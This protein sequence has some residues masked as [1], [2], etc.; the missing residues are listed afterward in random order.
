ML[1]DRL[2]PSPHWARCIHR[3]KLSSPSFR[4][5]CPVRVGPIELPLS[6]AVRCTSSLRKKS[7]EKRPTEGE[8]IKSA[9]PT[10]ESDALSIPPTF[11]LAKSL[12]D[13]KRPIDVTGYW[14]SE[15][16]DG[17]RAQWSPDRRAF[18][19]RL[20][21]VFTAPDWYTS[22]LP[23]IPL[24]GELWVG[25]GLFSETVSIVKTIDSTEWHK[26][27]FVVFDVPD[28]SFGPF[29]ERQSEVKKFISSLPSDCQHIA[30][31]EQHRCS[32]Q[33]HLDK[34]LKD[35]EASGGEGVML[36][37]P[38]S[39]YVGKRSRTLLK[40]KSFYD[41]E[42]I[43]VEHISGTGKFSGLMG[44]LKCRMEC[45]NSFRIGTGFTDF[46]RANP[47]PVGSIVTYRFFELTKEGI[48]RFPSFVSVR[49]DAKGPKDA[50]IRRS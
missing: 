47:P 25:R 20:G 8:R 33:A 16:L 28:A 17:V 26:V 49:I 6:V 24:D 40:L 3:G 48:P 2:C 50:T 14:M 45:G 21:N 39:L 43:I 4:P 29:E 11:L 22:V 15:K 10:S 41:A 1:F 38:G 30:C 23:Q 13:Y 9:L 31:I 27:K 32:G 12:R 42:A 7:E 5:P 34:F 18:I 37:E 44:S 36:R 46:E 19:S 35:I